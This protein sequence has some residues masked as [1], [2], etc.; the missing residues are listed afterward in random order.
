ML[1][2]LHN[3]GGPF[4]K[5]RESAPLRYFYATMAVRFGST[6]KCSSEIFPRHYDGPFLKYR[7]SAPLIYFYAT[8]T[9]RFLNTVWVGTN[10]FKVRF[11]ALK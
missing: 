9:V 7:E 5:Y 10:I 8:M 3:Y 1:Y 6:E 11:M 4:L 2:S